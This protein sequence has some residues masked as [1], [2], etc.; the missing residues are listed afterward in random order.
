VVVQVILH[1]L[2]LEKILIVGT[3]RARHLAN[4]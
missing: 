2:A 3:G 4:T 1:F